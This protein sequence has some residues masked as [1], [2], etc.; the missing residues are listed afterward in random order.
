MLKNSLI[1]LLPFAILFGSVYYVAFDLDFHELEFNRT[2]VSQAYGNDFAMNL[3]SNLLNYYS[4]EEP[5]NESYYTEKE[6]SHLEDVKALSKEFLAAIMVSIILLGLSVY[7]NRS[8]ALKPL[9]LGS[10][11]LIIM[12]VAL[13]IVDFS[14]LFEE[15]HLASFDNDYWQLNPDEH[16]LVNVFTFEFFK[17]LFTRAAFISMIIALLS[18]LAC[19]IAIQKKSIKFKNQLS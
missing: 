10:I 11:L 9:M 8:S 2:G 12:V 15:F 13:S 5:L 3:S 7:I 14:V 18:L 16:I 4:D 1:I 17:D 6:I 19:I